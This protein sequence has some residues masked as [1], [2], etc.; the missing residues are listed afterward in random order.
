MNYLSAEL[1]SK[2]YGPKTLFENLTFGI[3]RGQ[4]IALVGRN[5][6]GKSSLLRILAGID[7]ADKGQVSIR[8]GI[9]VEFLVQAPDFDEADT[10]MDAVFSGDDPILSTVRAYQ[11][12]TSGK[13][14]DPD[15]MQRT[16]ENM[17]NLQAWDYENRC[18]EILG[19]LGVHQLDQPIQELSGGQKKR[20]ALAKVLVHEP[21]FLILDEPTNHL[22]TDSIEWLENHLAASKVTLMLVT[23]DRYFLDRVCNEIMEL[24][25]GEAFRYVG[26]YEHFLTKKSEREVKE[27]GDAAKA[28]NLLRKEL[29]WLRRQPKARTTKSK[30]KVE[31]VH[32]LIDDAVGPAADKGLQMSF[33]SRRLGSKI[34]EID[35]LS[36]AYGDLVLIDDFNYVFKKKER[37]GIVGPNGVGKST[38][39]N[40]LTNRIE[41]DKGTVVAGE[42]IQF[43]YFTQTGLDFKEGDL[44][45][46]V[47]K[48]AAEY[49]SMGKGDRLPASQALTL[50]GFPPPMQRNHVSEL[51]GGEKRRLY[52]LR[53]L[54]EQPNFLIL[55]EPTNDLD[56]ITMNTLEEFLL[57]FEGCLVIVSHD[58]YFLNKLC[59]HL[60]VFEGEGKIRDFPGNYAQYREKKA[61]EEAE[62]GSPPPA[63]SKDKREKEAPQSD[64]RKLSF[65]EKREYESLE[66]EIEELEGKKADLIG[67]INGGETDY[68]KITAWST[69]LEATNALLEEK[70]DRWLELAERAE[71]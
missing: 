55:D 64:S 60:F 56:L 31:M 9:R 67:L 66:N 57:G 15:K 63:S 32:G 24:D 44:V 47:I 23:H 30:A 49:I 4:K 27:A 71:E 52:L 16:M 61:Q 62:A 53:V 37:I 48:D 20:V 40:L 13:E 58:R 21:D 70:S 12:I 22:D 5:G 69:E 35:H 50:F 36:K 68:E 8:N 14:T 1:L 65:N 33:E 18:K 45:I 26:D 11:A 3:N 2:S 39:V 17:E 25:K 34:I 7:Q 59:D 43:G 28:S 41:P 42:T 46:D 29:E 54:M 19:K 38:F 51:S 10:V 6:C